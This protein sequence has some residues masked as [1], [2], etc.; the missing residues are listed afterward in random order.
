MWEFF[1]QLLSQLPSRDFVQASVTGAFEKAIQSFRATA[2]TTQQQA[3]RLL[4][5]QRP[6]D[7]GESDEVRDSL[8]STRAGLDRMQQMLASLKTSSE[9]E[10]ESGG[11]DHVVVDNLKDIPKEEPR[12][13]V[14]PGVFK[15]VIEKLDNL[16]NKQSDEWKSKTED[17]RKAAY[18]ARFGPEA[19]ENFVDSF[20][21]DKQADA[22]KAW[23]GKEINRRLKAS[24]EPSS[25]QEPPKQPRTPSA[26]PVKPSRMA[27][28]LQSFGRRLQ[29]WG[30]RMS[31]MG[32]RVPS[33]LGR[34]LG[35]AG[36]ALQ[37]VGRAGALAGGGLGAMGAAGA[38]VGVF[39]VAVTAAVGSVYAF[40]KGSKAA[41][42]GL[43][44]QQRKY[45]SMSGGQA[46]AMGLTTLN[47]LQN[48]I[49]TAQGTEMATMALAQEMSEF[50]DAM[51][52]IDQLVTNLELAVV[53]KLVDAA[54]AVVNGLNSLG[55]P[56]IELAGESAKWMTWIQG[57][58]QQQQ[59]M[60]E[61]FVE[62]GLRAARA[63][64]NRPGMAPMEQI[65][66]NLRNAPPAAPRPPIQ[67]IP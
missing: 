14:E 50:R 47:Q 4:R 9:K 58:N 7:R 25:P 12:D 67:P 33:M 44:E 54:T 13:A 56:M 45:A 1:E 55:D 30:G 63:V 21:K 5:L 39:A 29:M 20:P 42:E 60:A 41:G 37:G 57:G 8:N 46:Q 43:L 62:M 38:A 66:Q 59:A 48:D 6:E 2:T 26:P 31:A 22:S 40:V 16:A 23:W 3:V 52:P 36:M 61:R 19:H 15:S 17:E 18:E 64:N 27:R 11:P 65:L 34:G 35:R 32:G 49:K 28:R 24:F 10:A 51:Q 53:A